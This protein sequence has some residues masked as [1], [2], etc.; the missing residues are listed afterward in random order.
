MRQIMIVAAAALA[1]A[2]VACAG[3]I[4]FIKLNP[5]DSQDAGRVAQSRSSAPPQSHSSAPPQSHSSAPP[6]SHSS[7]PPRSGTPGH[8]EAPRSTVTVTEP[9]TEQA[10]APAP[11][12]QAPDQSDADADFLALI[13]A[14]GIKAP[15]D[16]AIKAG[17]ATC[18]EDYDTAYSYLTDGGLYGYHVQTF[19]DD[20]TITHGGC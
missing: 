13:A 1:A 4:A 9:R 11:A 3:A 10:P 19:L 2:V 20:W 16:W 14:E 7:A 18:G 8:R 15:D 12:P 17:R 5:E 6:Q